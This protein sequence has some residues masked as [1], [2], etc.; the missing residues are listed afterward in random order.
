MLTGTGFQRFN[1]TFYWIASL[2]VLIPK[3]VMINEGAKGSVRKEKGYQ[4]HY[5]FYMRHMILWQISSYTTIRLKN[6][7]LFGG[8]DLDDLNGDRAN[9]FFSEN[10]KF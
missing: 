4:M 10:V 8:C 3:R 9:F 7:R 2:T 5:P 1:F 6:L